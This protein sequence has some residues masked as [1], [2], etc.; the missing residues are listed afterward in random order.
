MKDQRRRKH[1]NKK[2]LKPENG[3]MVWV[4]NDN[5]EVALRRL[6]KKV[7]QA[8]TM[9]E[10]YDRQYFVKPSVIK[11]QKKNLAKYKASNKSKR[12]K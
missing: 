1:F 7:E 9:R 12:G 5:V 11:R 10:V 8:G 4:Y 6:K 3:L 2:K